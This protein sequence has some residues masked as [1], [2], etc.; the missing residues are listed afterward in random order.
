[1]VI[2]HSYVSLPFTIMIHHNTMKYQSFEEKTIQNSS[3]FEGKLD[4]VLV[5]W[6]WSL[7][8][9][10][11]GRPIQKFWVSPAWEC[12]TSRRRGLRMVKLWKYM[13]NHQYIGMFTF[14]FLGTS[15]ISQWRM[16]WI[17]WFEHD[18]DLTSDIEVPRQKWF[19][20]LVMARS[21]QR[22]CYSTMWVPKMVNYDRHLSLQWI[23]IND[24]M[25]INISCIPA[26]AYLNPGVPHV[27][28]RNHEARPSLRGKE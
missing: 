21:W 16:K 12:W 9:L 23:N 14:F 27:H 15:L 26:V 7:D 24:S 20:T 17:W 19:K 3:G 25:I 8:R 6:G 22:D 18:L 2:F 4:T 1:M 10:Y 13:K 28:L 11:E 5:T